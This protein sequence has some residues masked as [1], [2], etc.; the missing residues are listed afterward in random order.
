MITE[1]LKEG[2]REG[3]KEGG[4]VDTY[5]WR[6]V[7]VLS[8]LAHSSDSVGVFRDGI[9]AV[10]GREVCR[11]SRHFDVEVLCVGFYSQGARARL[12]SGT[13]GREGGA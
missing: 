2:G 4:Q 9:A 12:C 1:S 13:A 3:R 8:S 7:P 10:Q 5:C 6:H 11:R